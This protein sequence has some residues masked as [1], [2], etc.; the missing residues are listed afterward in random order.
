MIGHG[1]RTLLEAGSSSS[2][3][4]SNSAGGVAA[5]TPNTEA[6]PPKA[7]FVPKPVSVLPD[8][9]NPLASQQYQLV[10][11]PRSVALGAKWAHEVFD[12]ASGA[13]LEALAK[14][15]KAPPGCI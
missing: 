11:P 7:L 4:S 3:T 9:V 14:G 15:E 5:D 10:G 12:V 6:L 1:R 13:C 2:N 8:D